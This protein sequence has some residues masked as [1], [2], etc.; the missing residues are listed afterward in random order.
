LSTNLFGDDSDSFIPRNRQPSIIKRVN[1]ANNINIEDTLLNETIINGHRRNKWKKIFFAIVFVAFIALICFVSFY[2]TCRPSSIIEFQQK[3]KNLI[4]HVNFKASTSH[5]K[6]FISQMSTFCSE[7]FFQF[8]NFAKYGFDQSKPRVEAIFN[9][10]SIELELI[11]AKIVLAC[12]QSC[13]A[14]D[15]SR[16]FQ[17]DQNSK[18]SNL[19]E[20]LNEEYDVDQKILNLA[21]FSEGASIL[22]EQNRLYPFNFHLGTCPVDVIIFFQ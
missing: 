17:L 1:Q 16:M 15:N 8:L 18:A 14:L 4:S 3:A 22:Y 9:L 5:V 13:K 21:S 20:I 19:N 7:L 11:M 2:A 6:E 10:L 12:S